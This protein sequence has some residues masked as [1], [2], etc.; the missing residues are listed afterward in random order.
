MNVCTKVET[1]AKDSHWWWNLVDTADDTDRVFIY[2]WYHGSSLR[3][4]LIVFVFSGHFQSCTLSNNLHLLCLGNEAHLVRVCLSAHSLSAPSQTSVCVRLSLFK[5]LFITELSI[6]AYHKCCLLWLKALPASGLW[7]I[8]L[9][10]PHVPQSKCLEKVASGSS[11]G[12]MISIS[13]ISTPRKSTGD[14]F[15]VLLLCAKVLL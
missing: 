6:K 14:A 10:S 3:V 12:W 2:L 8:E 5:Q 9:Y 15:L 11:L 4:S 13:C 7:R 1:A